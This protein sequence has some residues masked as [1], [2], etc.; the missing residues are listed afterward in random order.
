MPLVLILALAGSLALHGAALFGTDVELFGGGPTPPPLLAELQPPPPL[1]EAPLRPPPQSAGHGGRKGAHRG[2]ARGGVPVAGTPDARPGP[3]LDSEMLPPPLPE[4]AL[5][6]SVPPVAAAARPVLAAHG[7]IRFAIVKE[8]LD[9]QVGRA[10]H[11]WTFA[12]DGRY[13]LQGITETT[14]L[15]A[16][17]K[18]V[19]LEVVSEGRMAPGGLQPDRF[20]TTKNG[21]DANENADFDWA[22]QVVTLSRDGSVRD[23]ARGTQDLLSLNYQLA[24][25]GRLAEGS[26]IGV[27]TGKK[28][29]RYVLDSLGEED[30]ETPVG[31]FRTLHLRAMTDNTTEIWIA[32]D[33]QR[34]PV[35]IRFTDKKGESFVQVV[36]EIGTEAEARPPTLP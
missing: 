24:Y 30:I 35:K 28:Y 16:L 12:E 15:A 23:I 20:R 1:A 22:A 31:R 33:R 17:F 7:V 5:T 6:S 10:E 14:G 9:L 21:R 32:L 8:S 13:R 3:E 34:L 4:T 25:L 26:T 11:R 2:E 27:V 19:R 29:E 18:S 36:T